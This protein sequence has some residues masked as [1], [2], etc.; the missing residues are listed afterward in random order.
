MPLPEANLLARIERYLK[1]C[2]PAV[3][4]IKV[5]G[6]GYGRNG[7]PDLHVLAGGAPWYIEVKA[8]GKVSTKIQIEMQRRIK[9]AGGR[10]LVVDNY[11]QFVREFAA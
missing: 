2:G 3:W 10:V 6:S 5:H 8:P 7:V 9:A 1:T 11:E 4:W